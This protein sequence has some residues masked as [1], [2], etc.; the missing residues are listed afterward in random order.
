MASRL[1][2]REVVEHDRVIGTMQGDMFTPESNFIIS[3]ITHYITTP[4][5]SGFLV[6]IKSKMNSY[7][8]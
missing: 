5:Q 4:N 8:W 7:E 3:E 2:R 6:K 1:K